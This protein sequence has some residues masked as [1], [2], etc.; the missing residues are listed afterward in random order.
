MKEVAGSDDHGSKNGTHLLESKVDELQEKNEVM[1]RR[2]SLLTQEKE[3]S[4][5]IMERRTA[6]LNQL[7]SILR[8]LNASGVCVMGFMCRA[9]S[10]GGRDSNDKDGEG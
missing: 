10:A 1:E 3:E 2:L 9:H 6:E 8:E 7:K 4:A 5:E